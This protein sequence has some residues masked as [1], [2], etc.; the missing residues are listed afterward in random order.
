MINK[1]TIFSSWRE[2]CGIAGYTADLVGAIEKNENYKIEVVKI[3]RVEISEEYD[4]NILNLL[5]D[6]ANEAKTISHIQHEF[7]FFGDSFTKSC[8]NFSNFLKFL[9]SKKILV[10]FHTLPPVHPLNIKILLTKVFREGRLGFQKIFSELADYYYWR[11]AVKVINKKNITC[12]VHNKRSA[13]QLSRVG[14]DEN[15]IKIIPLGINND[16]ERSKI[17]PLEAKIKLGYNESDILVG[18]FGFV[19]DYKDPVSACKAVLSLPEEFKLAIVG[20]RHPENRSDNAI[21]LVAK[22]VIAKKNNGRIRLTG[23]LQKNDIDLYRAACDIFIAPYKEVNLSSSA[24]VT[25]ALSSGKPLIATTISA[26][27]DI[28]RQYECM[29]MTG[30]EKPNELAWAIKKISEDSHL[31]EK[32]ISGSN[33]YTQENSWESISKEYYSLYNF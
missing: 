14:I 30:I 21:S 24:A 25:W 31:R 9:P 23:F 17:S 26:F 5:R 1:I 10:T 28:N 15:F 16:I 6:L 7:S 11:K 22:K 8:K 13:L 19:A 12:I 33:K 27:V 18:V 2:P 3:P 32:L 20:G 29:L 4:K